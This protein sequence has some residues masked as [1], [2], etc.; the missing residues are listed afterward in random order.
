MRVHRKRHR[1]RDRPASFSAAGVQRP[2]DGV[3]VK[4]DLLEEVRRLC[5]CGGSRR[6]RGASASPARRPEAH[7]RASATV[8]AGARVCAQSAHQDPGNALRAAG[9]NLEVRRRGCRWDHDAAYLAGIVLELVEVRHSSQG[10]RE[11]TWSCHRG[12]H[13]PFNLCLDRL[14]GRRLYRGRRRS[15]TA[16]RASAERFEPARPR[17]VLLTHDAAVL[18][19]CRRAFGSRCRTQRLQRLFSRTGSRTRRQSTRI[20]PRAPREAR[21]ASQ[22][23]APGVRPPVQCQLMTPRSPTAK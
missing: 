7:R 15:S 1:R 16:S 23:V 2:P 11:E 17:R 5:R 4:V 21:V 12:R 22:R 10:S 20:H 8:V 6:T 9:T 13:V 14:H 3:L 18:P 19:L